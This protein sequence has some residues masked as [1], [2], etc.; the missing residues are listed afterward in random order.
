MRNFIFSIPKK[1]LCYDKVALLEKASRRYLSDNPGTQGPFGSVQKQDLCVH[2]MDIN[3]DVTTLSPESRHRWY[4]NR[5]NQ[6][7]LNR[8]QIR[9]ARTL[10]IV[11]EETDP[12]ACSSFLDVGAGSGIFLQALG[13]G[14]GVDSHPGCVEAMQRKGIRAVHS[15]NN[16]LP[17]ENNTFAYGSIF[18][19]LEHVENPIM[20]LREMKR[21]IRSKIF[22]SVPY[23]K[24][25][26]IGDRDSNG[27]KREENY[28]FFEL[29]PRDLYKLCERLGL[30]VC[31]QELMTPYSSSGLPIFYRSMNR[32]LPGRLIKPEWLFMVLERR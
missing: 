28:H 16:H 30:R 21:V 14:T 27:E 29:S 15:R 26:Q 5:Q 23:V 20:L 1:I 19:C 6:L 3:A 4:E 12:G 31:R 18:E 7:R 9:L 11:Q 17:F 8:F 10:Q 32:L 24:T 2:V 25:S 22:I 13:G